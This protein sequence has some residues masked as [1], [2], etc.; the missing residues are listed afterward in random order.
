MLEGFTS[1]L[2]LFLEMIT[3]AD[4]RFMQC[5]TCL[6]KIRAIYLQGKQDPVLFL[7]F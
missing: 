5:N 2:K 1:Q 4:C 3:I 6:G 7:E